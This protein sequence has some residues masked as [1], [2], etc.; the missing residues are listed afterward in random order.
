MS[1]NPQAVFGAT[2]ASAVNPP[3]AK[4]EVDDRARSKLRVWLGWRDRTTESHR[5]G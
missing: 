2:R 3:G 1:G 4:P 5:R